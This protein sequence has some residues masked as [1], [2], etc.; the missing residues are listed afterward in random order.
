M[1]RTRVYLCC[2]SQKLL[3][4]LRQMLFYDNW[5]PNKQLLFL[6]LSINSWFFLSCMI[7]NIPNLL[8]QIVSV[9]K[10]TKQKP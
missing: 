2:L 1:F 8:E 6:D 9:Y 4:T 5:P 7:I 3:P 10:L